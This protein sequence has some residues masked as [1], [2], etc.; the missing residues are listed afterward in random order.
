MKS[1]FIRI[2]N[3]FLALADKPAKIVGYKT[4]RKFINQIRR[5]YIVDIFVETGTFL[6]DTIYEFKSKFKCLYSIE[7][8]PELAK[9]AKVRFADYNHITVIEGDSGIE[10]K[11]LVVSLKEQALFWLDGH[12]SSSFVHNGEFIVTAKAQYNTPILNELTIILKSNYDHIILVDDARL[13][14]G[15]NDYPRVDELEKL[16]LEHKPFY[17]IGIKHDIIYILPKV[18]K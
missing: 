17:E 1:F 13:F 18:L 8:S 7:L 5:K 3:Y 4:K 10:L 11:T 12:Y 6:G 15:A 14:V 16:V 2:I 9:R